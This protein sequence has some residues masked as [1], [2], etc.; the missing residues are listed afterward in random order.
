[1]GETANIGKVLRFDEI[2]LL[3]PVQSQCVE[4]TVTAL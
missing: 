2:K 3:T 4:P 1:M